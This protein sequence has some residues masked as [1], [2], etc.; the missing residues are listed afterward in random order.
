MNPP[1]PGGF[2]PPS[3]I[4]ANPVPGKLL[5]SASSLEVDYLGLK[6]PNHSG[7]IDRFGAVGGATDP[8]IDGN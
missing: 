5:I 4:P 1:G 8:G 7:G 2:P 6:A 3:S